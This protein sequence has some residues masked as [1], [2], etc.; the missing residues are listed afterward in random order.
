[1]VR[2]TDAA[3]RG[4][5]RIRR[6]RA[7]T[8]YR[9]PAAVLSDEAAVAGR[10]VR[11]S[12]HLEADEHKLGEAGAKS[13]GMGRKR[14]SP[15]SQAGVAEEHLKARPARVVE[16]PGTDP[17]AV[18]QVHRPRGVPGEFDA[19]RERGDAV[20]GR[21]EGDLQREVPVPRGALGRVAGEEDEGEA[22]GGA[23]GGRRCEEEG[24]GEGGVGWER[25]R[26]RE[27][28]VG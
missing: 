15:G 10:V 3:R 6:A 28:R 12:R 26:E 13:R 17:V 14:G 18:P 20:P 4:R 9:R 2:P 24:G 21:V 22:G 5:S 1:V 16:D 25:Q 19:A 23:R 11:R 7:G 27:E 8:R